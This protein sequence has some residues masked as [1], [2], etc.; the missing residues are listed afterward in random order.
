M[1]STLSRHSNSSRMSTQCKPALS[2]PCLLIHVNHDADSICRFV[3][4]V[5]ASCDLRVVL[6]FDGAQH[7]ISSQSKAE[8]TSRGSKHMDLPG[9]YCSLSPENIAVVA[10]EGQDKWQE[11]DYVPITITLAG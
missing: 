11:I 7:D 3:G 4:L 1:V 9:E 8:L 6:V 10:N 2:H 5:S